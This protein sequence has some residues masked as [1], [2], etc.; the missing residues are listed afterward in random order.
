MLHERT[1][2]LREYFEEG[3]DCACFD[4]PD[5]IAEK[6][7]YYLE[8]DDER[9]AVAAAGRRRCLEFGYSV[10]D[11]ARTVLAKA[12]ALQ[13]SAREPLPA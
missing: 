11:R 3:V 13:T 7:R 10:D 2:E 5:E 1:Q 12:L 6:V 8:R 9:R 4:D